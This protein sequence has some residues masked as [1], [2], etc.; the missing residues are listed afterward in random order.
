MDTSLLAAHEE[1]GKGRQ[2]I[3]EACASVPFAACMQQVRQRLHIA[4]SILQVV[5]CI[6]DSGDFAMLVSCA[7]ACPSMAATSNF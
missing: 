6:K 7:A 4:V 3:L 5:P 1:L 2:E